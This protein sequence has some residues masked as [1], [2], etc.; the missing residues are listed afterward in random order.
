MKRKKLSTF[1]LF[2]CLLAAV[3]VV[4]LVL[5]K[6]AHDRE[7][8]NMADVILKDRSDFEAFSLELRRDDNSSLDSEEREQFDRLLDFL[9]AYKVKQIKDSDAA[10][11]G[12]HN[13][14][15][16]DLFVSKQ[17][18]SSSDH[19]I[20]LDE[21]VYAADSGHYRVTNGPI[22]LTWLE[23]FITENQQQ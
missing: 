10:A 16:A 7:G 11:A 18:H 4:L 20:V 1:T 5:W 21:F 6:V 22:D 8:K 14:D 3:L 17:G 23:K 12:V 15:G 19:F 9:A 2:I 13:A